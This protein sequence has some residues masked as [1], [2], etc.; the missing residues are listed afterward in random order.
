MWRRAALCL[1]SAFLFVAPTAAQELVRGGTL[2]FGINSGDPPTY[3]CHQSVLFPIIHLLTPHY[4]NLLKI[5]TIHYPKLIGDLA[6]S[7]TFRGGS[8]RERD[9]EFPV[10]DRET[11]NMHRHDPDRFGS[12]RFLGLI[13]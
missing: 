8:S 9:R 6:Q 1:L 10:T 7:W 11:R 13:S 12:D 2:I 4:S 3:D 5:D